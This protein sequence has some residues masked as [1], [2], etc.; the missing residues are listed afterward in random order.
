MPINEVEIYTAEITLQANGRLAVDES[1]AFKRLDANPKHIYYRNLTSWQEAQRIS[2]GATVNGK[3]AQYFGP[4]RNNPGFRGDIAENPQLAASIHFEVERVYFE[5]ENGLWDFHFGLAKAEQGTIKIRM[6]PVGVTAWLF[7]Q[8]IGRPVGKVAGTGGSAL[9]AY[10]TKLYNPRLVIVGVKAPRASSV[11]ARFAEAKVAASLSADS[12]IEA[13]W[14]LLSPQGQ[15]IMPVYNVRESYIGDVQNITDGKIER[16]S[17]DAYLTPKDPN[18]PARYRVLHFDTGRKA[19]YLELTLGH[20]SASERVA[21][22]SQ[23]VHTTNST[24][25][26][27]AP[28]VIQLPSDKT[29][30][31]RVIVCKDNWSYSSNC[32]TVRTLLTESSQQGNRLAVRILEPVVNAEVLLRIYLHGGTLYEPALGKKFVHQ[33]YHFWKFGGKPTWAYW[34][35]TLFFLIAAIV[36][37]ILFVRFTRRQ[38][39]RRLAQERAAE[40]Q[41]R[42]NRILLFLRQHDPNFSLEAFYRRGR[43]IATRIQHSW[44]AGD[45]RDCRRFLSQGVYNRFRLQLKLMREFEHRRN[46]MADFQIRSFA[47]ISYDRSGEFDCLTVRLEAEARDTWVSVETSPIASQKAAARSP[48][49]HFVEYYSFMRRASATSNQEQSLAN[50]SRCGTPFPPEGETNKCKSCGAVMGS[51]EFDWVLA[52]ITQES[53]YRIRRSKKNLPDE[54]SPDRLEDRASYI[55][56]RDTMARL[57]G[58]I[59]YIRR[60]ATEEYLAHPLKKQM[61]YDI[62]VG[63]VDV[64]SFEEKDDSATARVLVK[65]SAADHQGAMA[66]HRRS[67]LHLEVQKQH[68]AKSGFADPGCPACGAPLLETDS[69]ECSYCHSPIQRKNADWL[70][71]RVK[72]TVE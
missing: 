52:E 31:A 7:D 3:T 58:D 70:L 40:Q 5:S 46:V 13:E 51:G 2:P 62:A 11:V 23:R 39:E 10:S 37:V 14:Q 71:S 16:Y 65:W 6:L 63:A 56:W 53:E 36:A 66:R 19:E 24:Y 68:W 34:S 57:T 4:L 30:L 54:L 43:E 21:A 41:K 64:E 50:C 45:M 26:A 18:S 47:A 9:L 20:A 35:S 28:V 60:D 59:N 49:H 1:L 27:F 69:I 12:T 25:T 42:E 8:N 22:E 67:I 17:M 33:I 48:L 32:E 72:T 55:F 38:K 29:A 61:L 44:S 15:W